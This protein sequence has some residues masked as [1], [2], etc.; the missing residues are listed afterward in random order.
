MASVGTYRKESIVSENE[1][2]DIT[3]DAM[4]FTRSSNDYESNRK[5][6]RAS[7]YASSKF[8]WQLLGFLLLLLVVKL[9][10]VI[11]YTA[12]C[13]GCKPILT[14]LYQMVVAGFLIG[15]PN[16]VLLF[17]H[18]RE[19]D[20]LNILSEIGLNMII[21]TA[22]FFGWI[23]LFILDPGNVHADGKWSWH[24]LT[25]FM[26]FSFFMLSIPLQIYYSYKMEEWNE[27][28]EAFS[29]I[30]ESERGRE[31]FKAHLAEEVSIENYLFYE[32]AKKWKSSY[33]SRKKKTVRLF[34]FLYDTFINDGSLLQINIS[35]KTKKEL[36]I[37]RM[38]QENQLTRDIF[39]NCIFEVF[40]MMLDSYPRFLRSEHHER[41][42]AHITDS[43]MLD[44]SL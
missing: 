42:K 8:G 11:Y 36:D 21:P 3:S 4:S 24:Y 10:S 5:L 35:E 40:Q 31:L 32:G 27:R 37:V 28:D 9:V 33:H 22:L 25:V 13:T 14:D 44:N 23:I 2:V 12:E 19:P 29:K 30:L 41:Y 43:G 39:D 38:N 18:H 34:N 17:I 1:S 16:Y 6:R 20:P 26:S 7:Y 15:V